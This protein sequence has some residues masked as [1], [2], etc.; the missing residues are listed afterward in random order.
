MRVVI[1]VLASIGG[2]SCFATVCPQG[3]PGMPVTVYDTPA[4]VCKSKLAAKDFLL[5]QHCI[6]PESVITEPGF[7]RA[8]VQMKNS[9][10]YV[11]EIEFNDPIEKEMASL[12]QSEVSDSGEASS[13]FVGSLDGKSDLETVGVDVLVDGHQ[14][15]FNLDTGAEHTNLEPDAQSKLFAKLGESQSS[16]VEGQARSCDIVGLPRLQIGAG[17]LKNLAVSRCNGE[18]GNNLA[19]DVFLDKIVRLDF[20]KSSVT[21][22]NERP[23]RK[24]YYRMQRNQSGLVVLPVS[25]E[26]VHTHALFDTGTALTV[27]DTKFVKSHPK[28]FKRLG[29]GTV[30]DINGAPLKTTFYEATLQVGD[31]NLEHVKMEAL[32]LGD[33][34][35]YPIILGNNVILKGRW[36]LDLQDNKWAMDV[37]P[38]AT[39]SR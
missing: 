3:A 34:R 10:M 33:A 29:T 24:S 23:D 2:F 38:E 6:M 13:L 5:D 20:E 7:Y 35:V 28:L 37:V 21:L 25:V 19:I 27:V 12:R 36:I 18:T 14:K 31:L 1:L 17:D 15:R 11:Y 30:T 9:E 16:N 26:D 8:C 22:M 39:A 4:S 32:P